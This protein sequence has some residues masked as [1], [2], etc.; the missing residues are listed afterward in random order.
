MTGPPE[1]LKLPIR[2]RCFSD[3][4]VIQLLLRVPMAESGTQASKRGNCLSLFGSRVRPGFNLPRRELTGLS[5][6]SVQLLGQASE[7]L[8]CGAM[9]PAL[10]IG[11]ALRPLRVESCLDPDSPSGLVFQAIEIIGNH[12][13]SAS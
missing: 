2:E 13:G 6:P 10:P 7:R 11:D 12:F 5:G 4:S 1:A 3:L 9:L 8:L